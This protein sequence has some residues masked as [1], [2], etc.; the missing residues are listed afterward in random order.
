ML[1]LAIHIIGISLIVFAV[2]AY[3]YRK[4]ARAGERRTLRRIELEAEASN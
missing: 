2:G 4:G 3:A 1:L